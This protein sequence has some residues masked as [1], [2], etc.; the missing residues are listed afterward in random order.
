MIDLADLIVIPTRPSPNDLWSLGATLDLIKGSNIPFVFVATGR[1]GFERRPVTLGS[2]MNDRYEITVGLTRS[3]R[4]VAE[5]ALF[6]QF[7]ESQ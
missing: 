5:G 6:L 3:D 1:G 2:H 4:V 7:A